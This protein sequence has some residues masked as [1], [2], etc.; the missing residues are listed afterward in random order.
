MNKTIKTIVSLLLLLVALPTQA[1]VSSQNGWYA[2]NKTQDLALIYFG[3]SWRNKWTVDDFK[4]IVTHTFIDGHTDWFFPGFLFLELDYNGKT[5]GLGF[6]KENATRLDWE[7]YINQ[8]FMADRG[9]HALDECIEQYKRIIGPPPFKH[10][11]VV[12]IP[13]PVKDFMDW[14]KAN[15]RN[16]YFSRD[17]DRVA[18]VKWYIDTFL[19]RWRQEKFKNIELDGFYWNEESTRG[20]ASIVRPV[21]EVVHKTG[22]LFY[23]IPYF[24]AY[25]AL[26]WRELG[27]DIAY[28]QPNYF[29]RPGRLDKSR[30][31]ETCKTARQYGMGLEF[32][33]DHQYF[34]DKNTF[35]PRAIDYLDSYE[36]NGVWQYS[37]VA[38][39]FGAK[40]L[41]QLAASNELID[42]QLLDRWAGY[43]VE[44]NNRNRSQS[45]S[46]SSKVNTGSDNTQYGRT[47]PNLKRGNRK[48][49]PEDWRF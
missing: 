1:Q 7:K 16:L 34:D 32:E 23:W 14:G 20:V 37:A 40:T 13:T 45:A 12:V 5:I 3:A 31:E 33:F 47:P 42:K 43:V 17:N 22:L 39:Y 41:N 27:F 35:Y 9:F 26:S 36:R 4:P 29:F 25:G 11:I 24:N 10:K 18:A 44:R 48:L 19:A 49:N 28:L 38:Y 2:T 6:G 15:G 30:L 21:S 8:H 46:N